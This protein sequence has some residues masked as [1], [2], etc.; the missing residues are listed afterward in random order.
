MANTIAR[1][2]TMWL[3][4]TILL[5]VACLQYSIGMANQQQLIDMV[6]SHTDVDNIYNEINA[7]QW[8]DSNLSALSYLWNQDLTYATISRSTKDADII[9]LA[10]SN[11]LMQSIRHCHAIQITME[12]LHNFVLSK[13]Q[14]NNA[15]VRGR[16]TLLLGLAGYESDIPF[17][18]S[19]V[20]VEEQGYAEEAARSLTFIHSEAALNALRN[21]SEVVSRPSLKSYLERLITGYGRDHLIQRSIECDEIWAQDAEQSLIQDK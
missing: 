16:A 18:S 19:V 8:S 6:K 3:S 13:A 12:E 9:R 17:L 14:S 15:S 21:L 4:K 5:F 7:T 11:V 1:N 10:I 20:L 2:I